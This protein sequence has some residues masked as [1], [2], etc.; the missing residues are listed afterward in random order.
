MAS[1]FIVG[2]DVGTQNIRAAVAEVRRGKVLSLVA[3]LKMPSG[4]MRRGTVD[5]VADATRALSPMLSEIKKI[6]RGAIKNIILSIASPDVKV[7]HSRGVVAVSRAD[8]E[9]YQDDIARVLQSSQAVNLPANRTVLHSLVKEFIVDGID[10]IRDP[11]GMIGKRLEVNSFIIDAFAPSVKGL[12]RCIE[13]LGGGVMSV[14]LG[15]LAASRAVLTKAQK[16]LGVILIDIG[17]SKT[18]ICMYEENR[19]A[20][21]AVLPVGSA[22][23]TNDLAIG[24]R[25]PI[26]TAEI[27]KLSFGSALAKEVSARDVLELNK[28]DPR[29]HGVVS[30][31]FIAE[32][33]ES[34]LAEIFEQVNNEIKRIGKA[35]QLPAG[36]ILTG[37]A[38]KLPNLVELA[39]QEIKL[40]AQIGIPDVLALNPVN[41]E[42]GLQAE[43]PEYETAIGLL[44]YEGDESFEEKNPARPVS[45]WFKKILNYFIP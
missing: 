9:I 37:C 44:L 14:V 21:A 27:I 25:V 33:I 15:P 43:E 35:S 12:T 3:L 41:S 19:F 13:M 23:I 36:A 31:K 45:G 28:I 20:H 4:G 18:G 8:D 39:R 5:N 38:V 7:Q 26:E 16:E 32:I 10:T 29:V 34:R 17:F 42:L 24:L 1:N 2:L 40:S 11:L 22:S 30:K 6:S